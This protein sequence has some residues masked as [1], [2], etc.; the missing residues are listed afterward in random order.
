MKKLM[1]LAIAFSLSL[2]LSWNPLLMS[3]LQAQSEPFYK[4]KTIRIIVGSTTGGFYDRWAR[5]FSRYMGK[6]IPGNPEIIAQNMPA[7]GSLVATN[8]V[9]NV[10]KPDGLTLGMP[11][12]SIYLE[13]L[14]ARKE[15]QFDLRNFHWIGSPA[16]EATIL[17]MRADAPYT[18][19]A[20]IIKSTEL[21]KCGSTGTASQSYTFLKMLE[22][23]LGAKFNN[24]VGYQGGSEVD[25]AVEK[26]EVICRAHNISAHF[27]REPFNTW[28]RKGFDRH[29][30]QGSR[31]RDPRVQDTPTIYELFD[32]YKTPT[33]SR[34]V[35][36]V[37]MAEGDL[38]RPMMTTPGTPAERVGIL[39]EAYLKTLKDPELLA[40]TKKGRMDVVA[41]SGEELEA[42]VK[43]V[44]DAPPAVI[45]RARKILG[46]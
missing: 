14:A 31:K 4:G 26:G 45:E 13:Q 35:A 23:T 16:R 11:L 8:Y 38:G 15:V 12:S 42:L 46:N 5:L 40:E 9:Y 2:W 32:E 20:D 28:H 43:E 41:T 37:L 10:A 25:L 21:P 33:S 36:E 30:I 22:D 6:Y 19:M 44:M 29:I 17:Y 27:G 18:S 3:N 7:A 1:I 34:R 24:V 39:R